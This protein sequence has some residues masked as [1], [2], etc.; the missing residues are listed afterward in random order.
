MRRPVSPYC[1]VVLSPSKF[2]T[3]VSV[4]F[5]EKK[6]TRHDSRNPREDRAE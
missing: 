1:K 5:M 2:L 3:F 6:G 4:S